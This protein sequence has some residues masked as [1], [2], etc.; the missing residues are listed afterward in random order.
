MGE[1]YTGNGNVIDVVSE[2]SLCQHYEEWIG[3]QQSLDA[4][5]RGELPASSR[6]GSTRTWEKMVMAGVEE[7]EGFQTYLGRRRDQ[8][9]QPNNYKYGMWEDDSRAPA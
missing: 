3:T 8:T 4:K 1:C 5:T 7:E 9:Y 6:G 2:V